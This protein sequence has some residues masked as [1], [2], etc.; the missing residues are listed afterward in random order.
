MLLRPLFV[1][2]WDNRQFK[3]LDCTKEAHGT[4]FW[5][6]IGTETGLLNMYWM[7]VCMYVYVLY[8]MYV[9]MYVLFYYCITI[10]IAICTVCMYCMYVL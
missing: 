5:D 4:N 8:C 10:C 1:T 3:K 2:T 7:Y 9:C 6:R